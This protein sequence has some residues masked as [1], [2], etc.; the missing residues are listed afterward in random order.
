MYNPRFDLIVDQSKLKSC[1][2]FNNDIMVGEAGENLVQTIFKD[3]NVK[4]EVKKD[5]WTVR[6]GNIAIEF[7][8]RGKPS[9]IQTTAAHFWCHVVGHFFVLVFPVDFLKRTCNSLRR[10]PKYVKEM[11]DSNGNGGKVSKAILIPWKEL[12]D[13]FKAYEPKSCPN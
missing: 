9:G 6:T 1:F 3:K 12:L 4:L 8:C 13:R 10:N 11:G 7:E 5:D 2:N